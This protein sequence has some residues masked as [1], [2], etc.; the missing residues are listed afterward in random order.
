MAATHLFSKI[1][2]ARR[3]N[4]N[5]PRFISSVSITLKSLQFDPRVTP[6]NWVGVRLHKSR[7]IMATAEVLADTNMVRFD[8]I[9]QQ[10]SMQFSLIDIWICLDQVQVS[11]FVYIFRNDCF[12]FDIFCNDARWLND[13]NLGLQILKKRIYLLICYLQETMD[14]EVETSFSN[15]LL[16]CPVC[17]RP[18]IWNGAPLSV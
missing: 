13:L 2:F 3:F 11:N 10:I 18:L 1:C 12:C 16:A 15:D 6:L 4:S 17:Y 5:P 8:F 9:D 7:S 14:S